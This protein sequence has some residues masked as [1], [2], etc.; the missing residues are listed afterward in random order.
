[1]ENVDLAFKTDQ[2]KMHMFILIA[3]YKNILLIIYILMIQM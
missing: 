2:D 3:H 1:M